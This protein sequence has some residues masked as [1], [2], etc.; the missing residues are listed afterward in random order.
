MLYTFPSF[1]IIDK[2]CQTIMV[3]RAGGVLI[4]PFWPTQNWYPLVMKLCLK[5]PYLIKPGKDVLILNNKPG[6]P[7]S[8]HKHLHLLVCHVSGQHFNNIIDH[9]DQFILLWSHG[10]MLRPDISHILY[11][12]AT[13]LNQGCGY[14]AIN[15]ACSAL[16]TIFF[17]NNMSVAKHSSVKRYL[18]GVFNIKPSLPRYVNTWNVNIVLN[19]LKSK[20]FLWCHFTQRSILQISDF[21]CFVYWSNMSSFECAEVIGYEYH[22]WNCLLSCILITKTI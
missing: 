17:V 9:R 18:R 19:C 10:E 21:D 5:P 8:L 22:K 1:S 7:H 15:T 11:F 6:T 12:F 14:S 4:V 2:V 16:S 20:K 13:L 3:D